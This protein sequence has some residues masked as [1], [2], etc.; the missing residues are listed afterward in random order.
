MELFSKKYYK[1]N[2]KAN[3][4]TALKP[5]GKNPDKRIRLRLIRLH[6]ILAYNA[7]SDVIKKEIDNQVAIDILNTA[8]AD[9]VDED[10]VEETLMTPEQYQR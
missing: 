5:Y 3:V 2:V 7:A 9:M 6:T 4:Q 8:P 10:A 1:D